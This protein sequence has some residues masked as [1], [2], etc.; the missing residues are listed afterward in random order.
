LLER[1]VIP[2]FYSRDDHGIPT[3]WIKRLRESMAQ[4]TPR[5]SASR[6]V[7]EYTEQHYIPAAARYR[8][9]AANQGAVARQLI[10]WRH[11]VNWKWNSL[12]F[13]DVR[14]QSDSAH[15]VF[16][17]DLVLDGLDANAVR[18][19]LYADAL[20][21]GPAARVEMTCKHPQ[22]DAGG[23]CEYR[24]SVPNARPAMDYTPRVIP[25]RSG[26]AIPLESAR[27]LW[28]R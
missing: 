28:Q 21:G 19:E 12:R 13:G 3:A 2:E 26:V 16:E 23:R 4:L 14:V 1:E 8:E 24:A 7:R 10:D 22:P 15:H 18:V 9:R 27:I 17:L 25:Q 20:E 6:A 11:T 5:F